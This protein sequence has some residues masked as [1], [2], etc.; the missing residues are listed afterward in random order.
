MHKFHFCHSSHHQAVFQ[1]TLVVTLF[2]T[3]EAPKITPPS[4]TWCGTDKGT[5]YHYIWKCPKIQDL[6]KSEVSCRYFYH[7]VGEPYLPLITRGKVVDRCYIL[8]TTR[9]DG[10]WEAHYKIQDPLSQP[11]P[12]WAC[13]KIMSLPSLA[14]FFFLQQSLCGITRWIS[15]SF[16]FIDKVEERGSEIWW[17]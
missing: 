4:Q 5:Y 1:R 8:L 10:R 12:S 7:V 16:L 3:V 14:V 11:D 9:Q 6:K 15:F 13:V 2:N 17:T